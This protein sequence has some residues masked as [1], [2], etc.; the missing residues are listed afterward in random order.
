MINHVQVTYPLDSLLDV[1]KTINPINYNYI[2]Q[3]NL[4]TSLHIQAIQLNCQVI[5]FSGRQILK[6]I[7][8]K[9]FDL[10]GLPI[11]LPGLSPFSSTDFHELEAE[12]PHPR[13]PPP[14]SPS[15]IGDD[16]RQHA[17]G[18]PNCLHTGGLHPLPLL[19]GW[20]DHAM[21]VEISTAPIPFIHRRLWVPMR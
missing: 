1:L 19:W 18:R 2:S 12:P 6:T 20:S 3:T 11:P 8:C 15:S 14:R 13:S 5:A 9:S 16:G 17:E 21:T 4:K 10:P 7:Y